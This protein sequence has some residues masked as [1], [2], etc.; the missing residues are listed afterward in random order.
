VVTQTLISPWFFASGLPISEPYWA[1][2]TIRGTVMDV[3]IQAYERRALTYVPTNQPGWQVEM[4]NI[5]QHY[6]DWRYKNDGLCPG[7][8]VGTPTA[9]VPAPTTVAT[10]TTTP[11]ITR[12]VTPTGTP[13]ATCP[14]R[15]R[16]PTP[17]VPPA[18]IVPPGPGTRTPTPTRIP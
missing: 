3:L 13:C 17:A 9:P 12:T 18:T 7:T 10:A 11:G 6:F 15:T 2:A 16:T 5:G 4:A 1:K 14:T 8:V